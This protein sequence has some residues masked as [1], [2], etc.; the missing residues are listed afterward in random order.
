M[1][2][3][4]DVTKTNMVQTPPQPHGMSS[5]KLSMLSCNAWCVL[6]HLEVP[7]DVAY[8]CERCKEGDG[9]KHEEEHV[10]TEEGVAEELHCLQGAIHVGALVVVEEGIAKHKE[11]D[12]PVEGRIQRMAW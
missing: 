11:T 9:A 7:V 12:G 6:V 4:N 8:E 5:H 1:A 2:I 3:C 10:A